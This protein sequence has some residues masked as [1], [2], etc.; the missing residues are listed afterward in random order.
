MLSGAAP[1]S[2]YFQYGLSP[3]WQNYVDTWGNAALNYRLGLTPQS[4]GLGYPPSYYP[5]YYYGGWYPPVYNTAYYP[6]YVY[7]P[8]YDPYGGYLSGGADMVRAQGDLQN[9]LQQAKITKQRAEQAKLDT[10]R[11]AFDEYLYERGHRPTVEDDRERARMER[12]RRAR[13]QPPLTEI[14]S[15]YAL[16]TLLDA[17]QKMQAKGIQGPTISL[18]PDLR[19]KINVTTGASGEDFGLL[20]RG[21]RL[22]WP[23]TL[24]AAAYTKERQ[25]VDRLARAAYKQADQGMVQAD[26]VQDMKTAID[27]LYAELKSNIQRTSVNDYIQAKRYLDELSQAAQALG[28]P[29]VS[30]YVTGQWSAKGS[31]VA[32]LVANMTRQGL[33]FAP[34]TQGDEA[35]YTALHNDLVA[36]LV[37]A[38]SMRSWDPNTK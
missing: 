32:E 37:P 6:T 36:Y 7:S 5:Y 15:G 19:R 17:I 31:T 35:A 26:T 22:T 28:D 11:K 29:N 14:W 21:G 34:A 10:R 12:I 33:R 38:S 9:Q 2:A 18:D 23:A 3:K 1:T 30:K 20:R 25:R 24:R 8:T 16:N 13:N 27:K 4:Y